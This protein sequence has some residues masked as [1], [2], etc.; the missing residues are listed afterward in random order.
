MSTKTEQSRQGKKQLV[1]QE[2]VYQSNNQ[3]I[4]E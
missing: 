4:N 3:S 1:A 2:Q